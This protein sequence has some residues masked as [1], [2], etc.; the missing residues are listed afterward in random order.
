MQCTYPAGAG[1]V[2][3]GEVSCGSRSKVLVGGWVNE[4]YPT[5]KEKAER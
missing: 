4:V 1:A 2:G 5:S 3:A